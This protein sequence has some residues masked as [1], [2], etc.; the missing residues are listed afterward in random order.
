MS[1]EVQTVVSLVILSALDGSKSVSAQRIA[2]GTTMAMANLNIRQSGGCAIRCY[3]VA[4][5]ARAEEEKPAIGAEGN[6]SAPRR[7]KC[8]GQ[9]SLPCSTQ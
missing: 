5:R 4:L 9:S 8:P 2:F 7:G 3:A 1:R 6:S